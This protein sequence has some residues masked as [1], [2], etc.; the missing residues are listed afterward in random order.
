MD[1]KKFDKKEL[2]ELAQNIVMIKNIHPSAQY[3]F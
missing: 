1:D 3:F 2:I